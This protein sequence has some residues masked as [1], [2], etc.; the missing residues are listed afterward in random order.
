MTPILRALLPRQVGSFL[1]LLAGG[2]AYLLGCVLFEPEDPGFLLLLA[3]LLGAW[4]GACCQDLHQFAGSHRIP[5]FAS[6]VLTAYVAV[7]AVIG[8][9]T[10][11]LAIANRQLLTILPYLLAT[12]VIT[13]SLTVYQPHRF[14]H[15]LLACWVL[16]LLAP[17]V[18][19]DRI[20]ILLSAPAT[21]LSAGTILLLSLHW[22]FVLLSKPINQLRP[23]LRSSF[24]NNA[25]KVN[26]SA[27][28]AYGIEWRTPGIFALGL[29]AASVAMLYFNERAASS[30]HLMWIWLIIPAPVFSL[31]SAIYSAPRRWLVGAFESRDSL[32]LTLL[33]A[34]LAPS[35]IYTLAALPTMLIAHAL[36]APLPTKFLLTIL[37]AFAVSAL[38][39]GLIS[40]F[41]ENLANQRQSLRRALGVG[42]SMAAIMGVA[43]LEEQP[44]LIAI[45]VITAA[46][47]CFLYK[48]YRR[49]SNLEFNTY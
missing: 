37:A 41:S 8:L 32:S 35:T 16:S 12:T 26:R 17:D 33:L 42:L 38:I 4:L 10:I 19:G 48:G 11:L 21:S 23:S 45:A 30:V 15:I 13:S 34:V 46:A 29:I 47:V 9:F 1:L 20:A 25:R 24:N 39:L 5:W 27:V 40:S 36:H 2:L 14:F 49:I 18:P 28:G 31:H 6:R 43:A 7:L 44:I 3:I 22:L